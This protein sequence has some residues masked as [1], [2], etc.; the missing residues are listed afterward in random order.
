MLWRV[1]L[2][3][4]GRAKV[5][6]ALGEFEAAE[7][8]V[9]AGEMIEKTPTALQLRYLQTMVELSEE[10]STFTFIPLPMD[11]LDAFKGKLPKIEKGD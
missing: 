4:S 10:N 3:R 1:R 5:I 9:E 7:K 8:L 11:F 2:N 6:N